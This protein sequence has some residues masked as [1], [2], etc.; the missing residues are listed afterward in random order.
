MLAECRDRSG[1][2]F[3]NEARGSGFVGPW[4]DAGLGLARL[5]ADVRINFWVGRTKKFL[6]F[7]S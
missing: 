2:R 5:I 4:P 1:S 3:L 6:G 7:E